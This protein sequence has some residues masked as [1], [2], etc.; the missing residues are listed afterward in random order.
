MMPPI[1]GGHK[2]K[3]RETTELAMTLPVRNT[4]RL[5]Q[6]TLVTL[7]VLMVGG[8]ATVNLESHQPTNAAEALSVAASEEQAATAQDYLLRSAQQFQQQDNHAAAR[9][10]LTSDHF[11]PFASDLLERRHQQLAMTSAVAL[12][13]ETWAQALTAGI[14]AEYF[15]N[16]EPAELQA[17]AE[18]QA[19]AQE[20]AGNPLGAAYTRMSLVMNDPDADSQR[21]HNDIWQTLSQVPEKELEQAESEAIGYEA[22]GWIRLAVTLSDPE[23]NLDQQGRAIRSWQND[24]PGHPAAAILPSDLALIANLSEQ[25]PERIALAVPLTG[26]LANAGRAIRDGFLAAYYQ[27]ANRD[28]LDIII[29]DTA[30]RSFLEIYQELI[31]QDRELI[32]GPLQK[33]K[34]AE[35]SD[36]HTLPVP[37]LGL[38]YLQGDTKIP[39]GLF[40]FGLAPEDEARQIAERMNRDG[41]RQALALVPEGDWG[42]RVVA[43]LQ[44]EADAINGKLLDIQ[45]YYPEENL[46]AVTADLLGINASRDRAID[47]ERTAGMNVEFEPRRRQDAQAIIMVAR[48]EVGRQFN[49]LFA[50]YFGGDLPVYSPSLVYEGTED[51]SRDRDLNGVMFTDIP[52]ILNRTIPLRDIADNVFPDMAGGMH[53]LFAMGADGWQLSKRLPFLRQVD[54]ASLDGHTGQLTMNSGGA[55]AREQLWA[56]FTGG[57]P[58][59]RITPEE[60]HTTEENASGPL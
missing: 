53:R 36:M 26:P 14:T 57:S 9:T 23:L 42:D 13:D 29:T 51:P 2:R 15:L 37:V 1:D 44:S 17:V 31:E 39:A 25:Q 60:Q 10:L 22:E 50:F 16:Y 32:V 3:L 28:K 52:W 4:R 27:D 18:L 40:Q 33:E 19:R 6:L 24:W 59:L 20:V 8:C 49:P 35:L 11:H 21:L 34:L 58:E 7:L 12:K 38:N 48:P 56:R 41:I 30:E 54:G 45:R 47:V 46:R 43:A 55:I 5:R